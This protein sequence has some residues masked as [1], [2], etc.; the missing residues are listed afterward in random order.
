MGYG[1]DGYAY[2]FQTPAASNYSEYNNQAQ[3][4]PQQGHAVAEQS[5]YIT[6]QEGKVIVDG[7]E[8]DYNSQEYADYYAQYYAAAQAQGPQWCSRAQ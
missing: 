6:P 3:Y 2:T 4:Y 7:K 8:F 5:Q 1:D